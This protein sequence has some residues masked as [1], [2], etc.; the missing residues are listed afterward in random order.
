M[1]KK[2]HIG[3][4]FEDFLTEENILEEINVA[5]IKAVIARNL[6]EYMKNKHVTQTE[7]AKKLNTIPFAEN[8]SVSQNTWKQEFFL[9]L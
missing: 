3:A 7:M 2:K 6:K 5:A 4:S 9:A 8:F 1:K